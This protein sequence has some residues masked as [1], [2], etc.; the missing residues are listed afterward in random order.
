MVRW[1]C[2][3]ARCGDGGV[4]EKIL[5]G[6]GRVTDS[7]WRITR[8]HIGCHSAVSLPRPHGGREIPDLM[9]VPILSKATFNLGT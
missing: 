8:F 7:A 4:Q 5:D 9:F 2:Q 6:D 1:S 3:G